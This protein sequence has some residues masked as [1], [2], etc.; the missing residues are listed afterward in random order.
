MPD[1]DTIHTL[2]TTTNDIIHA[3]RDTIHCT[4]QKHTGMETDTE[5]NTTL[6]S[7]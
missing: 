6:T 7:Q 2:F 3:R 5:L 4:T 1:S